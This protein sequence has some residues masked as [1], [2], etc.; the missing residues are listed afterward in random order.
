MGGMGGGGGMGTLQALLS[1]MS[2]LK[3]PRGFVNR[4]VRRLL[5]MKPKPPPKY[6]IL[7]I[8]ATNMPQS[9]DEAMLRPGRIDRI[10]KVGYPSK[11]GRKATFDYY[12]AKVQHE[13][14]AGGHRQ[15]RHDHAVRHRRE[16]QGHRERG[17]RDRDPRRPRGRSTGRDVIRAKQLKEH[18][19]PDDSEY[20]EPRAARRRRST[21]RVT[22][23]PPTALRRHAV[24]DMATI[25]R[26]GDIGGLRLVDP[27]R[28]P[29]RPVAVRARRR[30][31]RAAWRRSPASGCSSTATTPPGVGG[32]MR[33]RHARSR[34]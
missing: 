32:D 21:R 7:H 10:Y 3:K 22:P 8:F 27:A 17:A 23:W 34:P 6:R 15:A 25:E 30:H 12:L 29:V 31:H 1:E 26:R 14:T 13:L 20:I 16:H 11:E 2:G 33:E 5:G 24:I 4:H 28:G 9:L 19:L 18:G